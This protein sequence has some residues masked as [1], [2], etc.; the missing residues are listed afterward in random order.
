LVDGT[1]GP[2]E[3]DFRCWSGLRSFDVWTKAVGFIPLAAELQ[4]WSEDFHIAGT[5]D[6]LGFVNGWPSV[7]DYKTSNEFRDDYW[8]QVSAYWYMFWKLVKI[9]PRKC[10]ILKLDKAQGIPVT[11]TIDN[12][13][14]R[15][16]DYVKV[17]KVYDVMQNI[18]EARKRD[19]HGKNVIRI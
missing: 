9:K 1:T 4:V 16:R 3:K 11:E 8:M 10:I 6:A 5:L 12:P 14:K 7:V 13:L 17:T 18:R 2:E 15:F 19:T